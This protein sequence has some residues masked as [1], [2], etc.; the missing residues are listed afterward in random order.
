MK[1]VTMKFGG[2]KGSGRHKLKDSLGVYVSCDEHKYCRKYFFFSL[3]CVTLQLEEGSLKGPHEAMKQ[4]TLNRE[5][6]SM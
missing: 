6:N 5:R 4:N 1:L 3:A 2:P